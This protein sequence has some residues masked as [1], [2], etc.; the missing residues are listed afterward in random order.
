[1]VNFT[2]SDFILLPQAD[3]NTRLSCFCDDQNTLLRMSSSKACKYCHQ[4]P[5]AF[6]NAIGVDHL[7]Q[8]Q[9]Q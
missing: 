6:Y 4:L 1:M 5:R 2:Q 7:P 9:Q 3:L 8:H